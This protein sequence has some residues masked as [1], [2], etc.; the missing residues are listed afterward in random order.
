MFANNDRLLSKQELIKRK[1]PL[2]NVN[3]TAAI[4]LIGAAL[5]ILGSGFVNAPGLY[6]TEDVEER[7]EIIEANRTRWLANQALV[8]LG[9]LMLVGGFA[10][11]ASSLRSA[12]AGWLTTFGT[13][14]IA[15]GTLSAVYF[16]YLQTV[17]PRGGY[18]GAYP[19]PEALAYWM[20]LA[21]TLLFGIA[22]LQSN[23][24]AWVGYLTAGVAL[25][26]SVIFLIT[27]AG[28]MAPFL[29]AILAAVIG[30]VLFRM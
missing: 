20:W 21:G 1:A 23:L 28:F 12:Q 10:A 11:L 18:S 19:L 27:G 14:A 26:Y 15:I 29:I 24:P 13:A 2:M 17:D 6:R 5:A 3:R 4:L 9:G 22:V 8:V 16:V 7:L 25:V 30:V